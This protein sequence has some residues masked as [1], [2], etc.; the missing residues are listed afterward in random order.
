MLACPVAL[1]LLDGGSERSRGGR[2]REGKAEG[3]PEKSQKEPD[4]A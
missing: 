2:N 1:D 4:T 3:P